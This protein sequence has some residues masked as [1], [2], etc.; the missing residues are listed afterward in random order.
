MCAIPPTA[1]G[2]SWSNTNFRLSILGGTTDKVTYWTYSFGKRQKINAI[3]NVVKVN[4][5]LKHDC[6][7]H[8]LKYNYSKYMLNVHMVCIQ[9]KREAV[10][11]LTNEM[12]SSGWI[13]RLVAPGATMVAGLDTTGAEV[14]GGTTIGLPTMKDDDFFDN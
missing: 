13:K 14:G 6:A 7:Q 9:L 10:Q 3:Y 12:S 8:K 4:G 1:Y 5:Q 2:Y 11:V